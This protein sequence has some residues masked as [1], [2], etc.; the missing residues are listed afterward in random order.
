[1]LKILFFYLFISI[2]IIWGITSCQDSK[3]SEKHKH[4]TEVRNKN[5]N[6]AEQEIWNYVKHTDIIDKTKII[7]YS[8]P[9]DTLQFNKVI[10]YDFNGQ[11]HQGIISSTIN[12]KF[13]RSISK[14]KAVSPEDLNFMLRV[15]TDTTTYGEVTASCFDPK[16][17]I[18]FF[19][20]N[21]L[22]LL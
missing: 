14:Q 12:K 16:L 11:A 8:A 17:G 6:L 13:N 22:F 7:K 3:H 18:V 10:A 9:F 20:D 2:F 21:T 5:T 4:K 15:L 19:Q 1:M